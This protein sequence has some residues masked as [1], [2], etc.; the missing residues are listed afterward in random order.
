MKQFTVKDFIAYNNPC[1]SCGEKIIFTF[2][3][4][5]NPVVSNTTCTVK[6]ITTYSTSL[7]LEIDLKTNRFK[8]SGSIG[9]LTAYEQA[10]K[11]ILQNSFRLHSK[12]SN[13]KT[14]FF[15]DALVLDFNK[16]IVKPCHVIQEYLVVKDKRF[17][18]TIFTEHDGSLLRVQD[19]KDGSIILDQDVDY[20]ITL[21]KIK[22]RKNI[23]NKLKTY[24]L[25]S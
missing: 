20:P 21:H 16:K 12:C 4:A 25:F 9:E 8:L 5:I 19:N 13:C 22:N 24:L 1:F 14:H 3:K 23:I 7:T 15:S 11:W 10:K 2:G 6:L 18:Y 17:N